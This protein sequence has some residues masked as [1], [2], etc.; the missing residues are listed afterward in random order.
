MGNAPGTAT[1]AGPLAQ[2]TN[3][4]EQSNSTEQYGP[5]PGK[6]PKKSPPPSLAA[7]APESACIS[8]LAASGND[9]MEGA[10]AARLGRPPLLGGTGDDCIPPELAAEFMVT[11]RGHLYGGNFTRLSCQIVSLAC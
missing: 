5:P 3:G 7:A 2:A 9:Q 10:P 11:G 1:A 4:T 8:S 6:K